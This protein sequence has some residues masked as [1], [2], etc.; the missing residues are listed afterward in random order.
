M[1]TKNFKVKNGL[2]IGDNI[3]IADDATITGIT[4]DNIPEGAVNKY[5]DFSTKTTDDLAEGTTNFYY[6]DTLA[7]QAISASGDLSYDSET[8]VISFSATAAPV[9]S[10]NGATGSVVLDTDDISEGATNKY[11]SD[12]LVSNYLSANSYATEGYVGTAIANLVD[13]APETLD[14]LNELA[15]AL[16][17]DP[18]FATT[19]TT[20]LGT[21]LNSADFDS[22]ADTW[23]SGK[24]TDNLT[25]G[26]TNRYYA[27]SL[28]DA[29]LSGG[30]GVDYTS[31]TISIGQ[32]VSTTS[33]VEFDRIYAAKQFAT[34]PLTSGVYATGSSPSSKP[35]GLFESYN[36]GTHGAIIVRDWGQ[37]GPYSFINYP[38]PIINIESVRGN[39]SAPQATTSGNYLGILNFAGHDGAEFCATDNNYGNFSMQVLSS[40]NYSNDGSGN[41]ANSGAYV[42]FL[43][44]PINT[45]LTPTSR[46]S[47]LN[48]EWYESS[49]SNVGGVNISGP[50]NMAIRWGQPA[51]SISDPGNNA[52]IK[53]VSTGE[54]FKYHGAMDN[55]FANSKFLVSGVD[56]TNYA[57]V[58]AS[59][60]NILLTVT[61]VISGKVTVGST[62]YDG[63]GQTNL[64]KIYAAGSGTGG[65]GSYYVADSRFTA[66][67]SGNQMT[68]SSFSGS[69]LFGDKLIR[70]GASV[71][72]PGWSLSTT[73][74]SQDSGT[75]GG[76][77]TYTLSTTGPTIT[78]G[79]C[80][81]RN[82]TNNTGTINM[83]IGPD[84]WSILGTNEYIISG[85]RG[86]GVSGRRL[87]LH[88][89]DN[90]GSF[91]FRGTWQDYATGQLG[92]GAVGAK[93]SARAKEEYTETNNGTNL[94]FRTRPI[95]SNKELVDT[96]LI[97]D[98][99]TVVSADQF[100]L[101]D[102]TGTALNGEQIN[103]SRTVL[104][105]HNHSTIAPAAVDTVY[106]VTF[107]ETPYEANN[108]SLVSNKEITFANTGKYRIRFS[109]QAVNSGS[110]SCHT[111]VW[112]SK[113]GSQLADS[114]KKITLLKSNTGDSASLY[115][116]E[117]LLDVTAGDYFV[118]QFASDATTVSLVAQAAGVPSEFTNTS[119][120][121]VPSATLIVVPVGA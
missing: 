63:S 31:G 10:V 44:Q 119:I 8:G 24:T 96:L 94:I 68:I 88:A 93:I 103:Y 36:S 54:E 113:N 82:G 71:Y 16:G 64:N 7:R 43:N 83:L 97:D 81:A 30:V 90:L 65:T 79:T 12:T 17:D 108:I 60:N 92:G 75:P 80:A 9:I 15:A 48:T 100:S 107:D 69:G 39:P 70:V 115:D 45:Y 76:T 121:A 110:S 42:K 117:W 46:Q 3:S 58:T 99:N 40:E 95:G 5:T 29:H 11:Y 91:V 14:T 25:E 19:V 34:R 85:N 57:V 6:S 38:V 33:Y 109:G 86:S 104:G 35:A 18:N 56:E 4:T 22:T 13:S 120:P 1:T 116:I 27:D 98:S 101:L 74:V 28:V 20:A 23:L 67:T 89:N 2:D 37:R 59:L 73:I 21:K 87:H 47:W 106:D 41:T 52:L 102:S 66:S 77:G 55:T 105:V 62:V 32:D 61:S 84:N 72:L 26:T 50:A 51:V 49:T 53:R 111:Y 114:G 118:I 112:L 78:N